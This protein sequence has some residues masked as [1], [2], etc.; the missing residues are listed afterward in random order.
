MVRHSAYGKRYAFQRT[1]HTADVL[2]HTRKVVLADKHTIGLDVEGD[3]YQ[4]LYETVC[5]FSLMPMRGV[6][7]VGA[8]IGGCAPA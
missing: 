3:V 2:K 6:K 1:D 4:Y 8:A 5:H 7:Q